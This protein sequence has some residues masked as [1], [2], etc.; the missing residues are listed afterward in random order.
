MQGLAR[1]GAH[2]GGRRPEASARARILR[3]PSPAGARIPGA[4]PLHLIVDREGTHTQAYARAWL[5]R[6]R[7]FRLHPTPAG[8]SCF[9]WVGAWLGELSRERAP[10]RSLMSLRALEGAIQTYIAGNPARPQPI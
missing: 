5:E 10:G 8:G 2:R 7:R 9:H 1:L 3:F 6:R 4:W